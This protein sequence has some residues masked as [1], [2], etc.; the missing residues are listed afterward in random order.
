[1]VLKW[2]AVLC[3]AVAMLVLAWAPVAFIANG[4][5]NDARRQ[6][7]SIVEMGDRRASVLP[8]FRLHSNAFLDPRHV[9]ILEPGPG[10]S[11]GLAPDAG[12]VR[13]GLAGWFGNA[14][15]PPL[16]SALAERPYARLVKLAA[17][18]HGVDARLVHAL[19]EVESSYRADAVSTAGAMGLMQLMPA[20]AQRY[21]VAD[22]LDPEA[23]IEAGTQHLR[24]LLDEFG[25][26]FA[27]DAL[28]AYHA[29]ESVVRQHGG[30][31]PYPGTHRF[32]RRVL[33]VLL[34]QT[35]WGGSG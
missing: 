27:L 1:M 8:A 9:P 33:H 21:G 2:G 34:S 28:A 14:G 31:P 25:P 30:I 29:G 35:G 7:T 4:G 15:P 20:T 3:C 19:I 24:G 17:D 13:G 6:L 12:D 10:A 22:P 11:A 18:R 16:R 5:V 23:N 32:V 26:L